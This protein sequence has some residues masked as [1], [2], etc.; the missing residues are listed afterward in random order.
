M[1]H[2]NKLASVALC[3][4]LVACGTAPTPTAITKYQNVVITLPKSKL[5]HCVMTPPPDQTVYTNADP[6]TR[7]QLLR[8]NDAD[9]MLNIK[10][11]NDQI[12]QAV[13]WQDLNIKLYQPD[14]NTV[15][16]G[17]SPV[18]PVTATGVSAVTPTK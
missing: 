18:V 5:Q 12:D 1:K 14:P 4:A 11:C 2:L 17:Q 3:A 16:V 13:S 15:W 9:Q 6:Q 7:E 8:A 10:N